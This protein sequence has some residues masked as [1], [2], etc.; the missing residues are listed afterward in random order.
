MFALPLINVFRSWLNRSRTS[1]ELSNMSDRQ[2]ADIGIARGDIDA[3]VRGHF[4]R[5]GRT[6][7]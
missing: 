2:L 3:V 1:Y 5:R 7:S 6:Y 4:E